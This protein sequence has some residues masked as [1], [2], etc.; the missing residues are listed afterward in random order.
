MRKKKLGRNILGTGIMLLIIGIVLT[1]FS[2]TIAAP[3]LIFISILV[4]T[5]GLFLLMTR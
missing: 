1:I 2:D 5:T 4:N 3:I